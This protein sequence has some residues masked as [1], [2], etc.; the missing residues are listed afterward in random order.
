MLRA[1][2][3]PPPHVPEAVPQHETIEPGPCTLRQPFSAAFYISKA[4]CLI[5]NS[6]KRLD[7][8]NHYEKCEVARRRWA[9][10]KQTAR[11]LWKKQ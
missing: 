2:L 10:P 9:T 8:Q 5:E 3:Q 6:L 11:M 4:S 1:A 7:G